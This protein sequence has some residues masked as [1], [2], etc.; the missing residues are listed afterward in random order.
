MVR[1]RAGECETVLDHVKAVH[2]VLR[3]GY[4]PARTRGAHRCEIPLSAIE[5]IAVERQ[6]HIRTLELG[7]QAKTAT[8]TQSRGKALRLAQQWFVTDTTQT[9]KHFL[10]FRAQ[11]LARGRMRFL[12]QER[13]AVALLC[14]DRLAKV[15]EISFEC[16][17]IAWLAVVKKPLRARGIIKIENGCLGEGV[18]R[19]AACGVQRIAFELDRTPIDGRRDERNG[20]PSTRHRG[21]IVE[22]FSRNA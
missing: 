6:D 12:D 21:R 9:R 3:R 19:A 8:K 22:K 10:Q 4:T 16:C 15:G 5:K 13:Q 20:P 14:Q 1:H 7:Y 17:A 2:R 18:S 11:T